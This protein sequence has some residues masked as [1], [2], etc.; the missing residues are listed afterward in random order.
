MVVE[1]D[2]RAV[3][4]TLG[5]L[6]EK[7]LEI[8][9]GTVADF[10]EDGETLRGEDPIPVESMTAELKKLIDAAGEI[11]G[12]V[13][14]GEG[15]LGK[16]VT[17][18]RLYMNLNDVARKVNEGEGTVGRFLTDETIYMNIEEF[19]QD[20]KEHPWKLMHKPRD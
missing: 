18:D 17:D 15:T 1:K 4:N 2:S 3:I 8:F 11:L 20:I 14:R 9:P 10:L 6:G 19:T 7:Y 13:N 16:F 12:R 5:L